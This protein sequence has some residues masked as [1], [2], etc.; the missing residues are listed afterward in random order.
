MHIIT[1]TKQ[2]SIGS[3]GVVPDESSGIGAPEIT[4]EMIEAGVAILN[5]H[6]SDEFRVLP[7][8]EIVRRLW[9]GMEGRRA[10]AS[11]S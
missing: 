7:D 9:L 11:R 4:A 3:F 1:M 8:E 10:L 6:T 5:R 2:R